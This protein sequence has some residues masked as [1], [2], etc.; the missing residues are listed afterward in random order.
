MPLRS[1]FTTNELDA[2]ADTM[3]ERG[4]RT[5]TGLDEVME[6][7]NG[8]RIPDASDESEEDLYGEGDIEQNAETLRRLRPY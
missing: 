6:G 8:R 1:V 2:L 5:R 4:L 7:W 3:A